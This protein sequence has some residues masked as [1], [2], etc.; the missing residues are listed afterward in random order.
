VLSITFAALQALIISQGYTSHGEKK[1]FSQTMDFIKETMTTEHGKIP[2]RKGRYSP[3]D[4]LDRRPNPVVASLKA[5][6]M[7]NGRIQQ[8]QIKHCVCFVGDYVFDSNQETALPIN[9]LSLDLICNAVVPGATYAGIFW[10]RELLLV[11]DKK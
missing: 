8:T 5:V 3:D 10:S 7:E 4:P 2:F 6:L 1:E 9:S 11:R